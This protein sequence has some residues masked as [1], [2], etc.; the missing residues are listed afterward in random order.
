MTKPLHLEQLSGV[1]CAHHHGEKASWLH[2]RCHPSDGL[3]A[4]FDL[5]LGALVLSCRQCKRLVAEVAVASLDLKKLEDEVRAVLDSTPGAV[6]VHEG[7]GPENLAASLAVTVAAL[8]S[9]GG[10]L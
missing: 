5:E 1:P 4:R 10:A 6:R 2:A 8:K 9:K 7:G 3:W